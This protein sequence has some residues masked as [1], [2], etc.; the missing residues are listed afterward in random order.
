MRAGGRILT[1]FGL[2]LA[3]IAGAATFLIL[4]S[5]PAVNPEG[6]TTIE[7]VEVVVAFQTIEP[8]QEIPIDALDVREYPQPI[9]PDAVLSDG[10]VITDTEAI[11]PT[12][13]GREFVAGKIS[14]TRIYPGQ[15]IVSTQ[16]VDKTIEE[17]R[18][19]LGGIASYIV[20]DGQVAT[21]LPLNPVSSINGALRAG[22]VVDIIATVGVL[23][24]ANPT[25]VPNNVAQFLLQR[26]EILR[27]GPWGV[28]TEEEEGDAGGGNLV[29]VIVEP[30]QALELKVIKEATVFE[31][32]LRS[33]TD[34]SDFVTEPVDLEYLIEQYNVRP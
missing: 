10:P 31:F 29:T 26:I 18:L 24:P 1:I 21:T 19:G 17:Q 25:G 20:P 34:E 11:T 14:N 27:V 15:V 4:Q 23:D 8:W 33:I 30:Q 7:S 12:L 22:D 28:T 3:M 32:V 5:E 6:A 13:T 9:P 16:L 2:I